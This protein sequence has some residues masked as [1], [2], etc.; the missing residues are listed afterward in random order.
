MQKLRY[1]TISLRKCWLIVL[2]FG[3]SSV[4]ADTLITAKEGSSQAGSP[5][6]SGIDLAQTKQIWLRADR[7]ANIG[8]G[9]RMIG[10]LDRGETY[11]IND[12]KK[13]CFRIKHQKYQE[14]KPAKDGSVFHKTSETR[15]VGSW[16]AVGYEANIA[17]DEGDT[18]DVAIW[19]SDEV[20]LGLEDYQTYTKGVVTPATTWVIDS[21]ALG[22]YPVRQETK[23]GP[24]TTWV[25]FLSVEDKKPPAGT[26]D[27]P[28]GYSGCE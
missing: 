7:M 10:R 8:D 11:L 25:E 6:A 1:M 4:E 28:A 20:R 19:I 16:E 13:T 15:Q 12:V 23:I 5:L 24:I 22:G 17:P 18:Y 9:S 2:C 21:L 14:Y 26:Y 3:L 27:V